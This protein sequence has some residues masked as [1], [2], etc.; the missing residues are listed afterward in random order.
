MPIL[1]ADPRRLGT[2][3]V[4]TLERAATCRFREA[5]TLYAGGHGLAAIY[6]YSYSVEMRIKA[7]YFRFDFRTQ[8]LDPQTVIDPARRN[9]A[10]SQFAILG[11]PKKPGPHDVL[12]WAELLV[13]KRVSLAMRYPPTL[14]REV[15]N[16]ARLL[17]ERWVETL[18]YRSNR[19]YGH[20]VRTV[21]E[22]AAWFD[23]NY[24]QL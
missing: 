6:L 19:P 10:V 4:P 22:V 8:G 11:L 16:Q 5:D 1:L 7:A 21:N 15:V 9:F 3:V 14:E 23:C 18:R 24:Y 2:D 17:S 20:E 12:G 13:A